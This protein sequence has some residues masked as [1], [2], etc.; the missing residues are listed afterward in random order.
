MC[1]VLMGPLRADKAE[2]YGGLTA[3]A[4]AADGDGNFVRHH[5]L[6]LAPP[7][8]WVENVMV[9]VSMLGGYFG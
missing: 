2:G 5:V 3:P 7:G 1:D 4:V 8:S 6:F 9:P